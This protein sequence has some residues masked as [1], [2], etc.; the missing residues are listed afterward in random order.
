MASGLAVEHALTRSVRDSAALLDATAGAAPGDPYPAPPS[1]EGGFAAAAGRDPGRLRIAY[2]I[3]PPDGHPV[4]P[5]CVAALRSAAKLCDSL[6]HRVVEADLPGLDERTGHAIGL[7]YGATLTWIV[8]YWIRIVGREPGPDDLEP[9]TRALWEQGRH[10][11]GGD[12]LLAVTDL[13]QFSRVV[14]SFFTEY[15]I[16]LTPTLAQPPVPLGHITSTVDDPWRAGRNG[17]PFVAFPAI[18]ANITGG[19]AMSVPLHWS[20]EGLPIGVHALGRV[21]A[22]ADLFSLAGQLERAQPWS[23]R[24]PAFTEAESTVIGE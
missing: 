7:A 13:Q 3:R 10:V 14:A 18:V 11:T 6:G 22:D 24:W 21:V 20:A 19:P 5:D 15:D 16:W 12:Y 9:F 2:S 1:P 4:H 17:A 8:N 23:H